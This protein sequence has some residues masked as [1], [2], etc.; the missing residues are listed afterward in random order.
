MAAVLRLAQNPGRLG[1]DLRS[2]GV[3]LGPEL[4][5]GGLD[6]LGFLL[7]L[8][9]DSATFFS[10]SARVRFSSKNNLAFASVRSAW[11]LAVNCS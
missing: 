4:F 7:A 6:L 2:L 9:S 3:D 1:L 5:G 10:V 11:A 8:C